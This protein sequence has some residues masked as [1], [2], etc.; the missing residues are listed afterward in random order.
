M[1]YLII[2]FLSSILINSF[3][4]S[5]Q[6]TFFNK[7]NKKRKGENLIISPLS[8]FQA[9]SLAANGA[10]NKAQSE[11]LNVLEIDFVDELNEINYIIYIY[12]KI[13]IR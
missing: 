8:I 13:L 9:L 5:F 4:C 6:A 7:I 2:L 10:N 3:D 12:S 1:R 11:I